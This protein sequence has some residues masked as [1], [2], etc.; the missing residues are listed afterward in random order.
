L[1]V[2]DRTETLH[3]LIELEKMQQTTEQLRLQ[4]TPEHLQQITEQLRLQLQLERQRANNSAG[5]IYYY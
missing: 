3:Q 5:T 1:K 4:Q 2:D